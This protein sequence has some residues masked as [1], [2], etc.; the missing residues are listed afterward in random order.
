[1]NI[2][3]V[4]NT[5]SLLYSFVRSVVVLIFLL[6]PNH[7]YAATS[8]TTSPN[9]R[10]AESNTDIPS[11]SL[12]QLQAL[13]PELRAYTLTKLGS[14]TPE[15]PDNP[16]IPLT[17]LLKDSCHNLDFY[18]DFPNGPIHW[19]TN[20]SQH[21]PVAWL[22][23]AA[24]DSDL[25]PEDRKKAWN[26]V[27]NRFEYLLAESLPLSNEQGDNNED[28]LSNF[29]DVKGDWQG[30]PLVTY[31]IPYAELTGL[32]VAKDAIVGHAWWMHWQQQNG[33][34]GFKQQ[35]GDPTFQS[36]AWMRRV[37]NL[38]LFSES[39]FLP[40]NLRA[41]LVK[42]ANDLLTWMLGKNSDG[43]INSI[44]W[45]TSE[46]AQYFDQAGSVDPRFYNGNRVVHLRFHEI[47]NDILLMLKNTKYYQEN[48]ALLDRAIANTRKTTSTIIRTSSILKFTNHPDITLTLTDFRA[49]AWYFDEPGNCQASQDCRAV[50]P[51]GTDDGAWVDLPFNQRQKGNYA[52]KPI[53]PWLD[54]TSKPMFKELLN[55]MCTE[56]LP[57]FRYMPGTVSANTRLLHTEKVACTL[58]A[59]GNG[60]SDALTDGLLF[61][62]YMFGSRGDALIDNAVATDCTRCNAADIEPLLAQCSSSL[63]SDIDGN[64]EVD[65]LTDGLLI[66]RYLFG[67]RGPA[68]I[69]DSVGAGCTRC[70]AS[71]IETYLETLN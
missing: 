19:A 1:M 21:D 25:S 18:P 31:L 8:P 63:A 35:P 44:G 15:L 2:N 6:L 20:R 36:R 28:N 70:T 59:D 30:H 47:W 45:D 40:A 29:N 53:A 68:L 41:H 46:Q 16:K 55:N 58:D 22:T 50:K 10:A 64:G 71:E 14:I 61:T 38:I 54:I 37:K 67:A 51:A 34:Q 48:S 12:T 39:S 11:Y 24:F 65:A 42:D 4:S 26:A 27:N 60:N 17:S 52:F 32:Q 5:S 62:R 57:S 9:L 3:L 7:L 13:T 66:T 23:M 49:R 69:V 33:D 56:W 43:S